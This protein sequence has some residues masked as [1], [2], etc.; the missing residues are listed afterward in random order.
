MTWIAFPFM[1]MGIPWRILR[2]LL[3]NPC[4]DHR[5]GFLVCPHRDTCLSNVAGIRKWIFRLVRCAYANAVSDSLAKA[6]NEHEEDTTSTIPYPTA[7]W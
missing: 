7:D 5:P 1:V 2:R 3:S 6:I 4:L